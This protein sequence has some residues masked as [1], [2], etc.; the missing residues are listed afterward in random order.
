MLH[1]QKGSVITQNCSHFVFHWINKTLLQQTDSGE[2]AF[3]PGLPSIF[4]EITPD[5]KD[6]ES[7]VA[8]AYP[9]DQ[10]LEVTIVYPKPCCFPHK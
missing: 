3:C 7:M 1:E 5:N 10:V 8:I 9:F 4:Q 2:C 6:N